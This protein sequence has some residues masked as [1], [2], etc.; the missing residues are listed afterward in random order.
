M[1]KILIVDDES[2]VLASFEKML[3]AQGHQVI[4]ARRAKEALNLLESDYPEVL[5]MDIRMPGM[6]GLEAFHHIRQFYPKL[7]VII[8]TGFGT[9]ESAIEATMLGAFDYLIKPFE[10]ENMLAII[11]RA[12]ESVRIMQRQVE[13][14]PGKSLSSSDAII[15]QSAA[16]REVYK[17]IGRVAQT[18]VT[19]LIRG[20]TGTGKELVARAIYQHSLRNNLPLMIMNCVA[21]PET[22]LESELFGHEKGAFTG[23][24]SKRI[25]KFEQGNGGTIL[26][27]EIGDIPLSIQAKILRVLE[28]KSFERIGSNDTINVDIR[29]IAATNR[30]LEKAISEDKFRED[31]YHRLNV[32][33]I[34][35]PPLRDRREDIPQ[36]AEY[37]LE[38][39]SE[40]LKVDKPSL[41]KQ[42][43]G[44]LMSQHWPG[45]VREL[46]HCLQRLIIFT[47]GYPIQISDVQQALEHPQES[48][49]PVTFS[50]TSQP[51]EIPESIRALELKVKI[52]V[53]QYLQTHSGSETWKRFLDMNEKLL[54]IE[55]LRLTKGN[56]TQAARILGLTRPTVQAKM[57]KY[58]IR[59]PINFNDQ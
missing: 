9:T 26:L 44:L 6:N 18:D 38:R 8:M 20:E 35:L 43:L 5:V 17:A 39:F 45:N 30:N 31:L 32:V 7:P 50:S 29:M 48:V 34:Y 33:S 58:R 56:Q 41:A 53:Q 4:T 42:A 25:G 40:Q 12:L 10:P 57:R 54:I 36:L 23:A 46:E 28:E 51:A 14:D 47:R 37:F 11:E 1:G 24:I 49:S 59:W 3:L 55:T 27:D 16:M 21:I 22:L 13:L 52:L 2:N 19:V 15:G